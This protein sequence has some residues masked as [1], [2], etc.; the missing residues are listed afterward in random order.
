M[1][2]PIQGHVAD[3]QVPFGPPP[4]GMAFQIRPLTWEE[5]LRLAPVLMLNSIFAIFAQAFV[6][7]VEVVYAL[8]LVCYEL[9]VLIAVLAGYLRSC[10]TWVV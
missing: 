4:P 1:R 2:H 8:W 7:A 9:F 10:L 6:L 5:E 3:A